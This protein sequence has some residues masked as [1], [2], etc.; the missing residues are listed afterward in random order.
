PPNGHHV[1]LARDSP[2]AI[3]LTHLEGVGVGERGLP[4]DDR[5]VVAAQLSLDDVLLA[6]EDLADLG[7]ELLRGGA[8]IGLRRAHPVGAGRDAVEEQHRLAEG[9]ARN[10]ARTQADTAQARVLL[11]DRGGLAELGR[12]DGGSLAGG[13]APD[14]YEVVVVRPHHHEAPELL[15]AARSRRSL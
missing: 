6:R 1:F 14:A 13:A 3:A 8:G 12:L 15:C 2:P 4:P 11:D 9:L 10:G 5:H 7:E